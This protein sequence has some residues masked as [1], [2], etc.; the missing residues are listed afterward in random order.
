LKF[1]GW[2][3]LGLVCGN[4]IIGRYESLSIKGNKNMH[5]KNT[6]YREFVESHILR[7]YQGMLF[8]NNKNPLHFSKTFYDAIPEYVS[9]NEDWASLTF[10]RIAGIFTKIDA[11]AFPSDLSAMVILTEAAKRGVEI[12]TN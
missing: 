2:F 11:N 6:V 9:K 5:L 7:P 4:V 3:L 1:G 12:D 10:S 8:P